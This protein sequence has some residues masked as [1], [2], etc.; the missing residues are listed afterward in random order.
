M[1][2][3]IDGELKHVLETFDIFFA[4]VH[5]LKLSHVI[6]DNNTFY[7]DYCDMLTTSNLKNDWCFLISVSL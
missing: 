3:E 1:I 7:I 5:S 4:V 6:I 2:R